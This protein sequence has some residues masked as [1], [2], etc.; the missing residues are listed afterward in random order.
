M[1]RWLFLCWIC[2]LVQTVFA[3]SCLTL[4]QSTATHLNTVDTDFR[5]SVAQARILD[6]Y[7]D[8]QLG[9]FRFVRS[10]DVGSSLRFNIR[11]LTKRVSLVYLFCLED[12][13]CVG[14]LITRNPWIPTGL[15]M[16]TIRG[17][18]DRAKGATI[19]TLDDDWAPIQVA[20]S[21]GGRID[22]YSCNGKLIVTL[23]PSGNYT[24]PFVHSGVFMRKLPPPK[25]R[26]KTLKRNI[27]N[28]WKISCFLMA[29]EFPPMAEQIEKL[30][31]EQEF[32]QSLK[33]IPIT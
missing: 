23:D 5:M 3:D 12:A 4:Q 6:D 30:L 29:S 31:D 21:S 19:S 15:L 25:N 33:S 10:I 32:I 2:L 9:V 26:C 24:Y 8:R 7:S 13:K 20:N 18:D 14:A 11:S 28:E 16:R 22:I 17:K 1:L 27:T